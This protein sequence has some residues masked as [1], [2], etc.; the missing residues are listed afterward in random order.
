MVPPIYNVSP[1]LDLQSTYGDIM[2]ASIVDVV[3]NTSQQ[4]STLHDILPMRG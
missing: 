4:Q 2:D 1:N 3:S